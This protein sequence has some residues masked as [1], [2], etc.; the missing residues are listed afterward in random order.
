M[1]D[2]SFPKLI[3]Q[4]CNH[5]I[6]TV[7]HNSTNNVDLSTPSGGIIF[8]KIDMMLIEVNQNA[9]LIWKY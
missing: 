4:F 5:L 3:L 1:G 8:S 7:C 6:A 9:N 2:F